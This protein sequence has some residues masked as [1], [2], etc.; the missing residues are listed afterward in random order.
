[1]CFVST[2]HDVWQTTNQN[3]EDPLD[4]TQYPLRPLMKSPR[5]DLLLFTE[6]VKVVCKTL[7]RKPLIIDVCTLALRNSA[8]NYMNNTMLRKRQIC[9]S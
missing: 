1:M 3:D 5:I 4:M 2:R 9:L 8:W 7:G 6:L